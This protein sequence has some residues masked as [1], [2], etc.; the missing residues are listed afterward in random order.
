VLRFSKVESEDIEVAEAAKAVG[1]TERSSA[2]EK[3]Y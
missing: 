3:K 1:V 2:R